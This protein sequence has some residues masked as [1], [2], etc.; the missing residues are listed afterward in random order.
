ML[1]HQPTNRGPKPGIV[2]LVV[3]VVAVQVSVTIVRIEIATNQITRFV[4]E[5]I[6]SILQSQPQNYVFSARP[7]G[8]DSAQRDGYVLFTHVPGWCFAW[9]VACF[10]WN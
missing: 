7:S 8:L 2:I 10:N 9:H 6:H 3:R 5:S 4:T 1:K